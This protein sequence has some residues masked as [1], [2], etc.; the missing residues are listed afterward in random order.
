MAKERQKTYIRPVGKASVVV[1]A[2]LCALC[3]LT[4]IPIVIQVLSSQGKVP[5]TVFVKPLCIVSAFVLML[6]ARKKNAP[7]I[8]VSVLI[9]I[10]AAVSGYLLVPA[11]EI[12]FVALIFAA[13]LLPTLLFAFIYF[14]KGR[15]RAA[16]ITFAVVQLVA[17]FAHWISAFVFQIASGAVSDS[18]ELLADLLCAVCCLLYSVALLI[19]CCAKY[20]AVKA[21][22]R[23][24]AAENFDG[25][26]E[27]YKRKK[28]EEIAARPNRY[29][30][31]KGVYAVSVAVM[32]IAAILAVLAAVIIDG[33]SKGVAQ[34]VSTPNYAVVIAVFLV[35]A[36]LLNAILGAKAKRFTWTV[37]ILL[38]LSVIFVASFI[39][40]YTYGGE[41]TTSV[42]RVLFSTISGPFPAF[43][44]LFALCAV[45][46]VIASR[47]SS[48]KAKT[49]AVA[50]MSALLMVALGV[51]TALVGLYFSDRT[52]TFNI[53][54]KTSWFIGMA[55]VLFSYI[56]FG[57]MLL[58]KARA[59][60]AEEFASYKAEKYAAAA[61]KKRIALEV[62]REKERIAAQKREEQRRIEEQRRLRIAEEKRLA[63]EEKEKQR[64][65]ALEEKEKQR[66]A[67]LEEKEKQR[68]AEEE[69]RRLAEE[70]KQRLEEEAERLREEE[71]RIAAEQAAEKAS[72]SCV[73]MPV[74]SDYIPHETYDASKSTTE[75]SAESVEWISDEEIAANRASAKTFVNARNIAL[76]LLFNVLTFGIYNFFWQYSIASQVRLLKGESKKGAGDEVM[77]M[78]AFG[79][80]YHA[81]WS[82]KSGGSLNAGAKKL[83]IELKINRVLYLIIAVLTFGLVTQILMQYNINRIA[84]EMNAAA[85]S[86]AVVLDR[87][88]SKVKKAYV[89][90]PLCIVTFGIY[91]LI[92]LYS[93][94]SKIRRLSGERGGFGEWLC[95]CI[96]PFYGL[97]WIVTRSAKLAGAM[98]KQGMEPQDNTFFAPLFASLLF[99]LLFPVALWLL[100]ENLNQVAVAMRSANGAQTAA[101]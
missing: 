66:L 20:I 46:P 26:M 59:F 91:Y 82:F 49:A 60:T 54:E 92:W 97:F 21:S 57:V 96:I 73:E 89:I 88:F 10:A 44:T 8:G 90:F 33:E 36:A 69:K 95:I 28:K 93:V 85:N 27:E 67:A 1:G 50:V 64:L 74:S 61:E 19:I 16:L 14:C 37:N 56:G 51:F 83:G 65:A 42:A 87:G 23:R 80:P 11:S 35:A 15:C 55:S 75:T 38:S 45:T 32:G 6:A 3:I 39:P 71:A 43:T 13:A 72:A 4:C 17:A 18:P 81:Y 99:G 68:L 5:L 31:N 22:N 63:A 78:F 9:A 47:Y 53:V 12:S 29:V 7:L 76:C 98:Q 58:G 77:L 2:V 79:I 41:P 40:S 24:E 94:V 62:K 48:C 30:V 25:A 70:E 84:R 52:V 86:S 34:P 100:Q 101:A